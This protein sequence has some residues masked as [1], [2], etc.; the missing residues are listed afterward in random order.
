MGG[1]KIGTPEKIRVGLSRKHFG[2][3]YVNFCISII[4][5]YD[6]AVIRKIENMLT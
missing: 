6:S 2:L 3:N 1:S 4:F 5:D